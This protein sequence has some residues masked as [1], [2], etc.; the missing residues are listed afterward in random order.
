MPEL[1]GPPGLEEQIRRVAWMQLTSL[2]LPIR[3]GG[4]LLVS[5]AVA[6]ARVALLPLLPQFVPKNGK[7]KTGL[8]QPRRLEPRSSA[9]TN[10]QELAMYVGAPSHPSH[11]LA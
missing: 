6:L 7:G 11:N 2:V 1:A 10:R 8:D 3:N 4:G 5:I 9:R